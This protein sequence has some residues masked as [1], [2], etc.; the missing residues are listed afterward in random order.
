MIIH[1]IILSR[2]ITSYHIRWYPLILESELQPPGSLSIIGFPLRH[3]RLVQLHG[4]GLECDWSQKK[5]PLQMSSNQAWSINKL[6]QLGDV[7]CHSMMFF[8]SLVQTSL[9]VLVFCVTRK[10][11]WHIAASACEG[12]PAE[13]VLH[14]TI[15][16]F[17]PTVH[18]TG[19]CGGVR[20]FSIQ[21]SI[22]TQ[23]R[24][25]FVGFKKMVSVCVLL[26]KCSQIEWSFVYLYHYLSFYLCIY[27]MYMQKQVIEHVDLGSPNSFRNDHLLHTTRCR[28][29]PSECRQFPRPFLKS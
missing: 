5:P 29:V 8:W 19:L 16:S 9:C 23:I 3:G 25:Q 6:D 27:N 26:L 18:T 24:H 22:N 21:N 1:V 15:W 17:R 13:V 4:G 10:S 2:H 14:G 12:I 28:P 11:P 7:Q 20:F